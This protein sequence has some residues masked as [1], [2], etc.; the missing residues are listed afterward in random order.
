M[1]E[2][3]LYHIW[4][5]RMCGPD[6][7]TT[8]GEPVQVLDPGTRNHDAGPDF[9]NAR[10]RV[11]NTLWA[12]NVEIHVRA[13]DWN[14]HGH[15]HDASYRNVVLHV[16][17]EAGSDASSG[18]PR[19]PMVELRHYVGT[20][21]AEKYGY[22]HR[23]G[24]TIPCRRLIDG[25]R[26]EAIESCMTRMGQ[27]RLAGKAARVGRL[28]EA[29]D[30]D[31]EQAFHQ[32]LARNFG[33]RLNAEPF[34][35]LAR[36]VPVR[37]I[38][39]QRDNLFQIESM[40]FGAAGLLDGPFT[41]RYPKALREEFRFLQRKYGIESMKGHAWKFARTRPMNFPT[42]RIAQFAMWHYRQGG[43]LGAMLENPD[44]GNLASM[45]R[46][47]T[48]EYWVG[49]FRFD[50]PARKSEKRL[51]DDSIANILINTVVPFLTQ[52]GQVRGR[53]ALVESARVLL[54]ELP[55]EENAATRTWARLG[56]RARH[57][58]DSQA[59]LHLKSCYCAS[60]RCLDCNI[61]RS[62]LSPR[63]AGT[64]SAR[65]TINAGS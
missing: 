46:A 31:R 12:G 6:L 25:A 64:V 60:H 22:L 11:G 48:S 7:V 54:R 10:I 45:F 9:F 55:P 51:G 2:E 21:A 8:G 3:F 4:S 34:E 27:E 61:G 35:W 20:D 16:V 26:P 30:G 56:V 28:V 52:Y 1:T 23:S 5:S 62:L 14:Q 40:L 63:R 50:K 49:H 41:D 65:Q 44:A 29:N 24:D 13:G 39:R 58:F 38:R 36:I 15:Q 47:G 32:L 59:L 17:Y 42:V 37:Y 19:I 43:N 53:D 33:F 57:A 18:F